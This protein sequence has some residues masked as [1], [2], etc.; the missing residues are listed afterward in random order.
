MQNTRIIGT[1]H[2]LPERILTNQE[3]ESFV[4]T[5][6][7]WIRQRT[8]IHQRHIAAKDEAV[9]DMSAVAARRAI[10]NAGIAPEEIDYI[11]CA[12]LTPD[13]VM[14]SAACFLQKH[15]GIRRV[16][17]VDINA[18]CSGFIYAL[19]MADA[20]IHSGRYRTILVVGAEKMSN[21]LEWNKRDT[22][23]L[24]GDGAG[25]VVVR[26][27]ETV[28]DQGAVLPGILS[29]FSTAD[30]A[31]CDLLY[32]P[33]GG[34]RYP[35]TPENAQEIEPGII[36]NGRELY[37]RAVVAFGEAI[38]EALKQAEVDPEEIT[39]FIPHQAN[40]RIIASAAGRLGMR[41]DLI[42]LNL[43][44]V[45]NTSAASI[46]IALDQA[47]QDGSLKTGDMLLLAAFGA[48]LTW[49]SAVIRW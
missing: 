23:V 32:V 25:A 19:E 14:P 16:A 44:K 29:V 24:F 37:K 3:M 46:P 47:V 27:G 41:E 9:S 36:M 48:G 15:L 33:Y 43:D 6:D 8:G 17:A 21:L 22:A 35:I 34:S 45:G 13:M 31:A 39:I 42:Y 1:G 12:T 26:A 2:Y 20:L 38:A 10:E 40:V 7:D 5:T 28:D 30:G 11:I 4:D 18:A 49:S